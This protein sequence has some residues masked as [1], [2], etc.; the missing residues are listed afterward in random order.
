MHRDR[1]SSY[2]GLSAAHREGVDYCVTVER[3][4]SGVIIVAPHGGRIERG[5][6]EVARAI[7]GDD[8]DLYLFEGLLPA[9]NFETLHLTSTRFDEPRALDLIAASDTV[10]V[11]HGLADTAERALIGGRDRAL[12]GGIADRLYARGVL[13]LTSGHRCPGLDP[14]NLCNRGRKG[15]G[16]QIELSDRLRGGR[17]QTAVIAAVRAALHGRAMTQR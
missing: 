17:Y 4:A 7:A 11:V 3:R 5:T 2:A 13:A 10:L 16:V 14:R 8:F 15:R 6:S 9:M 12:A 1:Y